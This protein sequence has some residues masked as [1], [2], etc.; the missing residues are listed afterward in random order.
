LKDGRAKKASLSI[1]EIDGERVEILS[2][3][4][5]GTEFLIGPNLSQLTDGV[6]VTIE[7]IVEK[8]TTQAQL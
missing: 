1:R 2:N 6:P 8:P 7:G 4:P 3:V 5:E